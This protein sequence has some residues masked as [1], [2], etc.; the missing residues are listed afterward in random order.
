ME[1]DD[2]GSFYSPSLTSLLGNAYTAGARIHSNSWGSFGTSSQGAYTSESEDVDDKANTYD[3][4]Y[5]GYQG[6]SI[7]FA[8]GFGFLILHF[9]PGTPF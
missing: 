9:V 4:Y 7:V 8:A 5:N 3:R 1:D 6:F 2:D